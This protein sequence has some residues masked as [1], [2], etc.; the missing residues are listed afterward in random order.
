[1]SWT[2]GEAAARAGVLS[3]VLARDRLAG[4]LAVLRGGARVLAHER[5][6]K[7]YDVW[8]KA[9]ALAREV[10]SL[11]HGFPRDER[12]GLTDQMRR[13]A[14]SIPSNLAEGWGRG[15]AAE[16]KQFA[17]LARGSACELET[18]FLLAGDLGYLG[19][20]DTS[21][22]EALLADVLALLGGILKPE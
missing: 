3:A 16:R 14:V 7:S 2:T 15:T 1:M 11:T 19:G 22:L 5:N 21:R 12:Y 4:S 18:Q 13:C 10:Y 9:M 6:Y 20:A 17:R 8:R